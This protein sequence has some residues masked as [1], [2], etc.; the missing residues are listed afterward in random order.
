MVRRKAPPLE[1]KIR[2]AIKS[3][4]RRVKLLP[5]EIFD[6][7]IIPNQAYRCCAQDARFP[8]NIDGKLHYLCPAAFCSLFPHIFSDIAGSGSLTAKKS[9]ACP[10]H[11]VNLQCVVT[12]PGEPGTPLPCGCYDFST[13]EIRIQD[14]KTKGEV[15]LPIQ[16]VLGSIAFP[17]FTA[18][19][20]LFPYYKTLKDGG[21]LGF[22]SDDTKSAVV[23]CPNI[24]NK[25]EFLIRRRSD[26]ALSYTVINA[27]GE[28]PR[29]Y[30]PHQ[31]FVIV[32]N[33]NISGYM[34][35]IIY[36]YAVNL[37]SDKAITSCRITDPFGDGTVVYEIVKVRP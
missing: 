10:D 28:C 12:R 31:E 11:R 3:V 16:Q 33:K 14:L 7:D 4:I 18:F 32:E 1:R 37:L 20:V 15:R 24:E 35:Y 6:A 19:Q 25:I 22:Y 27:K 30:K 13:I 9:V 5:Q 36:L 23:Q 2:N 26:G 8:F 17:C 34:L 29:G 21:S